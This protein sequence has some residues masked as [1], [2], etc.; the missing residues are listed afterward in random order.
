MVFPVVMYSCESWTVKTECQRIDTFKL[1]CWRRLPRVPW[2]ACRLHQSILK[3]INPEYSLERLMLKL[4]LQYFVHLMLMVIHW[5][6]ERYWG[7]K[8]RVSE[9]GMAGWHHQC[10]G[11]ELGQTFEGQ[12][13]WACCSPWSCK[14]PDTTGRLKNNKWNPYF[15]E[16]CFWRTGSPRKTNL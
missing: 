8:K 2:I 6:W 9:D 12:R 7:Q 4:M 10:N 1:W 15:N 14:K 11:H 13:G 5:C 16:P 3:E